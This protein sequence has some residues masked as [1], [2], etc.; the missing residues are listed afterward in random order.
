MPVTTFTYRVVHIISP[1]LETL[2]LFFFS[3]GDSK[4]LWEY[5]RT[6]AAAESDDGG[7]V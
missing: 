2:F 5:Y 1:R 4:L 7:D 6:P 3:G